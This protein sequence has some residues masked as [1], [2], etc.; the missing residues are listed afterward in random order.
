MDPTCTWPPSTSSQSALPSTLSST[1]T[2]NQAPPQTHQSH[3]EVPHNQSNHF[4]LLLA[5]SPDSLAGEAE[6][7]P[8]LMEA[9]RYGKRGSGAP[10]LPHLCGDVGGCLCT[11][12]YLFPQTLR[13]PC[14]C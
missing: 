4:L 7:A 3:G 6:S 9:V 8:S 12:L 10:E 11:L 13:R 5:V 1:S 2:R 14:C